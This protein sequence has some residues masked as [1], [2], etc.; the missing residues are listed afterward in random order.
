MATEMR[1]VLASAS[2]R[3]RALI[4]A[5]GWACMVDPV[6]VDERRQTAE[7]PE[8]YVL[9]L[10]RTKAEAGLL[11]HPEAV[12]LGADTCVVVD[13]DVLGK[14]ADDREA[15]SMLARL[16]GRAH[17][18]L[19]GVALASAPGVLTRLASTRVW[20]HPL[21]PDEIAWYVGSGEPMDKAGAYAIQGLAS[22]FIARI[23]GSYANVVGLPVADLLQLLRDAGFD[24]QIEACPP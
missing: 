15:A 20:M 21:G 16:S 17:Q 8:A 6:E 4:A 9:R 23:E 12:V 13:G 7:D 24:N 3:R 11:R 5:A 2:P 19:T 22:R 14:P 18:V 10:A 1:L